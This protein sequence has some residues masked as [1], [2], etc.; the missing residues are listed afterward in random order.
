MAD[1][2]INADAK[3]AADLSRFLHAILALSYDVPIAGNVTCVYC[4]NISECP[5]ENTLEAWKKKAAD[6]NVTKLAI[7]YINGWKH[8]C[9]YDSEWK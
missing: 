4:Q 3:T 2:V 5:N 6:N 7:W 1:L 9:L 8:E